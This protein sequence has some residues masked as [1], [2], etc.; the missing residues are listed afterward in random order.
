MKSQRTITEG[1]TESRKDDV[2]EALADAERRRIVRSVVAGSPGPVP[3]ETIES[4]LADATT[5]DSDDVRVDVR[6][7][8]VP[9]LRA[10]GLVTYEPDAR[11]LRYDGGE[12][13]EA[14]LGV[15]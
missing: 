13:C 4:T 1:T 9:R 6:H 10:A 7:N 5:S 8:H 14:I 15:A 11:H 3:L 2:L 12:F